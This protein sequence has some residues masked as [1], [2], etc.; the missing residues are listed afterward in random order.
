MDTSCSFLLFS[1]VMVAVMAHI[2]G[3]ML[4]VG[5][6]TDKKLLELRRVESQWVHT[7]EQLILLT[8]RLSL[9]VANRIFGELFLIIDNK[10]DRNSHT[11]LNSNVFRSLIIFCGDLSLCSLRCLLAH[12][13]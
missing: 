11:R 9:E 5:M 10:R 1:F 4:F 8:E 6:R 3:I 7:F 2:F 12:H 13:T